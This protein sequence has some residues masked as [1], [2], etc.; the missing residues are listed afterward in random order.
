MNRC[1]LEVGN[2][3]EYP[4]IHYKPTED[5]SRVFRDVLK[6]VNVNNDLQGGTLLS[7]SNLKNLFPFIYFDLTKQKMDIKDGV[8]KLSFHYELSG[9]TATDY[10]IYGVVL[11]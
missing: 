11:H 5:P 6:Y 2:G 3:N 4:R 1:Y 7:I 8:T 10:I 9:A